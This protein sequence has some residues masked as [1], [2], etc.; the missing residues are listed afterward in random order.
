MSGRITHPRKPV[1]GHHIKQRSKNKVPYIQCECG[2]IWHPQTKTVYD[3]HTD[4]PKI[5]FD[6]YT[7]YWDRV[8]GI[9]RHLD[10]MLWVYPK[11]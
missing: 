5:A 10:K 6:F 1:A 3:F 4:E 7:A 8:D 2:K 11:K 9:Y